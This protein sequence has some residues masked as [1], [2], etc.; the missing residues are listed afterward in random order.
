MW[1]ALLVKSDDFIIR[2]KGVEAGP[3]SLEL[4]REILRSGGE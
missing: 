3:V 4:I 1:A 2:E